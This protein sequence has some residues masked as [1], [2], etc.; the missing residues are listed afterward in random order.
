MEY[1]I[2]QQTIILN[3]PRYDSVINVPITGFTQQAIQLRQ[4]LESWSDK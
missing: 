2:E 4:V 3:G 1:T